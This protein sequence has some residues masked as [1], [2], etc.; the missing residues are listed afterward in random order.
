MLLCLHAEETL[1]TVLHAKRGF[2]V[3]ATL[4]KWQSAVDLLLNGTVSILTYPQRYSGLPLAVTVNFSILSKL[5]VCAWCDNKFYWQRVVSMMT[6]GWYI[7]RRVLPFHET[8]NGTSATPH[9]QQIFGGRRLLQYDHHHFNNG[10]VSPGV[11]GNK[12]RLAL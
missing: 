11:V 4:L 6:K 10:A 9:Q 5:Y 8:I 2:N 3:Q 12:S 7:S 1:I